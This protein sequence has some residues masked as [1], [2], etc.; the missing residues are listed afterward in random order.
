MSDPVLQ[1]Q[2]VA[3]NPDALARFYGDLFGWRVTASNALGYR[4]VEAGDHGIGGGIW[5]APPGAT[6]F[7]QLFVGVPDV[8]KAVARAA[9]L[10]AR[11]VIPPTVLP[12]G[13]AMAVLMDPCGITLGVMRTERPHS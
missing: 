1:W 10:G 2:L 4:Q 7:A 5:P 3:T 6:S 13:D 8:E 12:D 11:V 9:E